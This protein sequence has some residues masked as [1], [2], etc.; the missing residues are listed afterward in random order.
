MRTLSKPS[1]AKCALHL[2]TVFLL[3]ESKYVSCQRLAQIL[4]NVSPDS[5]NRFLVRER[6]T[7]HD[8]FAW[9]KPQK[10]LF[11]HNSLVQF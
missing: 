4:E 2:Y 5:I 6:Y 1:S 7:L 10:V 11:T 3:A 8:L 9:V